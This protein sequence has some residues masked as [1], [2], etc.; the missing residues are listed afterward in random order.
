MLQLHLKWA[1]DKIKQHVEQE[2]VAY[3]LQFRPRSRVH[4]TFHVSQLKKYMGKVLVHDVL[5]IIDNSGAWT[6]E[7]ARMLDRHVVKKGHHAVT[8]ILMEWENSFT[9]GAT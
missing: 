4:P 1:Q 5:P 8:E 2:K 3:R 6:K 9:K 7:P